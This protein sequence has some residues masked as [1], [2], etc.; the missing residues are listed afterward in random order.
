MLP[1]ALVGAALLS[2]GT[3][4]MAFAD[5]APKRSTWAEETPHSIPANAA[6]AWLVSQFE[7]GDNVWGDIDLTAETV[8]GLAAT[9]TSGDAAGRATT[10]LEG[11]TPS[12]LKSADGRTNIEGAAKLT[13]VALAVER[14]PTSFGGHN[15][16]DML[17]RAVQP[18]GL[19]GNDAD[20]NSS[21]FAQ[22]WAVMALNKT[23]GQ[24]GSDATV[25]DKAVGFLERSK[26]DDG[27]FPLKLVERPENSGTSDPNVTGS[28]PKS[29]MDP[30]RSCISNVDS[31]SMAVQA[32]RSVGRPAE[33]PKGSKDTLVKEALDWLD[34]RKGEHGGFSHTGNPD[35]PNNPESTAWAV[36]ALFAGGRR[37][38][39]NNGVLWLQK[40]QGKCGGPVGTGGD[41]AQLRITARALPALARK[42]LYKI[43]GT[44]ADKLVPVITCSSTDGTSGTTRSPSTEK[45]STSRATHRPSSKK[46]SSSPSPSDTASP[47][48]TATAT[49]TAT[50]TSDTTSG[51][52]GGSGGTTGTGTGTTSGSSSTTATDDTLARTGSSA[53]F[54]AA[55]GAGALLLAGSG[56]M[57]A[58][59]K[60]RNGAN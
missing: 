37:N 21:K 38:L 3:V 54:P 12:Y 39:A 41:F 14:K 30:P 29:R 34:R 52:T 11:N 53:A 17:Q 44:D 32:L 48:A 58:A 9:K 26:C 60:R 47:T 6:A 36:E 35:E 18:N 13:L 50:S 4:G 16:V 46:S 24:P 42:P 10:W 55:I 15:L 49:A 33:P 56:A 25:L 2:T 22:A 8:L 5:D 51:S 57:V 40:A 31:T 7:G 20:G 59:R 19:V 28:N 27:G 45:T 23:K 1:L 43:D